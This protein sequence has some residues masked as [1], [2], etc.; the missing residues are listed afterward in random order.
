LGDPTA[1]A[2]GRATLL[3]ELLEEGDE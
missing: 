1:D 2:Q 3:A